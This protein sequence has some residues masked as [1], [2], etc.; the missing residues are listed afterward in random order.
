MDEGELGAA[1]QY[2]SETGGLD[3]LLK[4]DSSALFIFGHLCCFCVSP[5]EFKSLERGGRGTRNSCAQREKM[6]FVVRFKMMRGEE[7][8]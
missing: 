5:A 2:D 3:S 7:E 4:G 1:S 8:K 6:K